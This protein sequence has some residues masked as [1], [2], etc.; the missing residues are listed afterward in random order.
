VEAKRYVPQLRGTPVRRVSHPI[1]P[2]F[3]SRPLGLTTL[4][5]RSAENTKPRNK[6]HRLHTHHIYRIARS[7]SGGHPSLVRFRTEAA[8]PDCPPSNSTERLLPFVTVS[9]S[10]SKTVV[11]LKSLGLFN[12][13][14]P[15][16]SRRQAR[17]CGF[18]NSPTSLASTSLTT[19]KSLTSHPG[20]SFSSDQGFTHRGRQT[21]ECAT[22]NLHDGISSVQRYV[23]TPAA[24]RFL[25]NPGGRRLGCGRRNLESAG[26]IPP[27]SDFPASPAPA[28][29]P[30]TLSAR[31]FPSSLL[32]T[33]LSR[34]QRP[35]RSSPLSPPHN[36]RCTHSC[37]P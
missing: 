37:C 34:L 14:R 15:T 23:T 36:L 3:P 16:S 9:C 21:G 10:F 7:V 28:N 2:P 11:T 25:G 4:R 31:L 18:S 29:P 32:S 35:S 8:D 12:S 33:C 30:E 13:R 5:A 19:I 26:C 20:D 24:P 6:H 22:C 27:P 1:P 17:L